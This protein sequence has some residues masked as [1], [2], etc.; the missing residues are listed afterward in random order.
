VELFFWVSDWKL[1]LSMAW[2]QGKSPNGD[3][4]VFD[5]IETFVSFSSIWCVCVALGCKMIVWQR[6]YQVRC[7]RR[8][9]R[10][11]TMERCGAVKISNVVLVFWCREVV[12]VGFLDL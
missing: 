2:R 3:A 5:N 6:N 8:K 12:G 7:A 10:G 9:S 1:L 4:M 11:A